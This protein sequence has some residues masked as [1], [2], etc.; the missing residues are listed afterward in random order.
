MPSWKIHDEWA[1]KLGT[2]KEISNYINRAV[3][4]IDVP[5]DFQKHTKGRKILFKVGSWRYISIADIAD[6][7]GKKNLHDRGKGQIH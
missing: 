5:E 1:R 7:V 6:I 4:G 3:D 2:S